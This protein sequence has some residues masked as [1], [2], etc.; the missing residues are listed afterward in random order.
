MI[1]SEIVRTRIEPDIKHKAEKILENIGIS[2]SSAINMFY[3]QIIFHDGL[4]FEARIPNSETQ[5][6]LLDSLLNRNMSDPI[7]FEEFKRKNS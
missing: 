5:D 1:K 4:P 6:A 7:T 2:R 3:K